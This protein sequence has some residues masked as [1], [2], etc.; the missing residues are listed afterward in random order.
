VGRLIIH[1]KQVQ[2]LNG[3]IYSFHGGVTLSDVVN[4]DP[5][6]V[7][8]QP[9]QI[10]GEVRMTQS[11][12]YEVSVQQRTVGKLLC[13]R[14]LTVFPTSLEATWV[15]TFTDKQELACD[16]E[17]EIIHLLTDGQIE[18]DPFVRE[19]LLISLPYAP[20]CKP[21]CA[22]LCPVCGVNKNIAACNCYTGRIDPRLAKLEQLIVEDEDSVS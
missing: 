9:V 3:G 14:C 16:N 13:A 4:D 2:Q 18:L 20:V 6:L 7:Q 10:I 12:L 15:E 21:D 8:L 1:V 5:D 22:G 19:Q 11:H 17:E